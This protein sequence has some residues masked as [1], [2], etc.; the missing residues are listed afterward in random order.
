MTREDTKKL[1]RIMS[2]LYPNWRPDEMEVAVD[3]WAAVLADKDGQ[4]MANALKEYART[5][6]SGFAPSPGQLMEIGKGFEKKVYWQRVSEAIT[7]KD[8]AALPEGKVSECWD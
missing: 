5:D 4:I 8:Y 7:L 2:A 3:A 6:T 1:L